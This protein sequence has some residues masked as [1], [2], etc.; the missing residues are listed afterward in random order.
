VFVVRRTVGLGVAASQGNR[1]AVLGDRVDRG[2]RKRV[3]VGPMVAA[4]A[5]AASTVAA[6]PVLGCRIPAERREHGLGGVGGRFDVGDAL[7]NV[8][9]AAEA[10]AV[11]CVDG[12]VDD[13]FSE[14]ADH[15]GT[16]NGQL[17]CVL[18]ARAGRYDNTAPPG[19]GA[20][21]NYRRPTTGRG[22]PGAVRRAFDGSTHAPRRRYEYTAKLLQSEPKTGVE[23]V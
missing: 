1:L 2:P 22:V 10:I 15:I 4:S 18:P 20:K 16:R 17:L 11:G 9:N 19:R 13:R 5:V 14:V 6:V 7:V 21:G 3:V 23:P 12:C 8:G